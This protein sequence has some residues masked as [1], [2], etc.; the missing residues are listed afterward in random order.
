MN[1]LL[2]VKEVPKATWALLE[3]WRGAAWSIV[4]NGEN[5][6]LD[7]CHWLLHAKNLQHALF[8]PNGSP[9]VRQAAESLVSWLD[10]RTDMGMSS[11]ENFARWWEADPG[12]RVTHPRWRRGLKRSQKQPFRPPAPRAKRRQNRT[13]A[14]HRCPR[15]SRDYLPI[16]GV[17]AKI[18]RL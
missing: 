7:G 18:R 2:A 15:R 11:R 13:A 9:E 1:H 16:A 5:D 12:S 10:G 3:A 14:K 8:C 17:L 4:S 6:S